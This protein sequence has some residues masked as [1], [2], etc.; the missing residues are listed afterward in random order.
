MLSDDLLKA[1]RE[2]APYIS[3]LNK[4]RE[5][6]L[7]LEGRS[8]D[9]VMEALREYGKEEDPTLRTDIKILLRYMEKE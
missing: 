3:H 9:E 7:S 6:L 5:I 2:A 8:K 4:E 1:Y